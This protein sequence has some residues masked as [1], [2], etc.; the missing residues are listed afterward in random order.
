MDTF[1][2]FVVDD[3]KEACLRLS[4]IIGK[5]PELK[6][7]GYDQDADRA[8]KT[9]IKTKPDIVFLDVEMP[10]MNGFE[11][12]GTVR[13]HNVFPTFIFI[14]AYSQYAINAIREK[15]FDYLLKPVD[16]REFKDTIERFK[17]RNQTTINFDHTSLTDREKQ[18]AR[19]LCE[20]K[21]SKEI[22]KQLF[23]S[24]NTVNTH[25]KSLLKKMGYR[26]TNELLSALSG[27]K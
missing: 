1:T 7:T 21:T 6:L 13:S 18:V 24:P 14:T 26:S 2:C 12:L 15:A 27:V 3:E 25:R 22:A 4:D 16:I 5:F 20:G 9:I 8:I 17:E 11:I 10:G 19:L 23:I